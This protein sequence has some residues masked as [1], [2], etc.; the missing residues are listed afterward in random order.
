MLNELLI[1]RM[2]CPVCGRYMFG[3]LKFWWCPFCGNNSEN[4]VI[5]APTSTARITARDENGIAVYIGEHSYRKK[6]YA[7]Y[8]SQFAMAE[9]LEKL[10]KME[11]EN[12]N[13]TI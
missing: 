8:L 1:G 5:A 6:T 3:D 12:E 9:I 11:E 10:C 13:E 7:P 2:R 4:E